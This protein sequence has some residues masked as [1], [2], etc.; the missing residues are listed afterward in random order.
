[1]LLHHPHQKCPC[2]SQYKYDECCKRYHDGAHPENALALMRSRY[3]AY[4]LQLVDYLIQSTDPKGKVYQSN[5]D[6]WKRDLR[7]FSESTAFSDLQIIDFQEGPDADT[8]TVT[9]RA[10]LWQGHHE[11]SFTEKSLFKKVNGRWMY[12]EALHLK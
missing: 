12:H 11:V 3:S 9:F 2:H 1:M 8:A 5:L 10:I 6:Q 7:K 4:A